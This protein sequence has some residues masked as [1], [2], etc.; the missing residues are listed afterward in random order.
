MIA[1]IST[2]AFLA[3]QAAP[4]AAGPVSTAPTD[5]DVKAPAV[6]SPD[7]GGLLKAPAFCITARMDQLG[8]VA[9][10]YIEDFKAKGWIP[11][12]GD[13]NRVIF[14]KRREG[15]GCDGMQMIAFFDTA[16]PQ[17]AEEPA[18]LGFANIP[19]DVCTASEGSNP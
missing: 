3:I 8:G 16:K 10:T 1:L 6:A 17:A 5:I 2:L 15:G 19:G 18:Y 11:A 4:V 9:E 14:I 12:D 7:C 13:D